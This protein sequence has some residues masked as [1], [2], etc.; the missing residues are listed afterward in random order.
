MAFAQ[1]DGAYRPRTR[2]ALQMFRFN[3]TKINNFYSVVS[4]K[5]HTNDSLYYAATVSKMTS[6]LGSLVFFM[7]NH[8]FYTEGCHTC[9]GAPV[10]Q[11]ELN[12]VRV[13]LNAIMIPSKIVPC[14][15]LEAYMKSFGAFR[16]S[17]G[18]VILNWETISENDNK[19]F[20]VEYSR[21]GKD[22]RPVGKV[23]SLGNTSSG[24][25]YSF[26]HTDPKEGKNYYRLRI[27][28][29][30]GRS[31][32]SEVRNVLFG[33]NLNTLSVYPNPASTT[34]NIQLDARDGEQVDINIFDANGRQVLKNKIVLNNQ[35]G[36]VNVERLHKGIYWI[37]AAT[38][39]GLQYRA[40][41][42][43]SN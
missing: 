3:S 35:I 10:T 19:Y 5:R 18:S 26:T 33:S 8:E 27:V 11:Q 1:F 23:L 24:F 43:I 12:G 40:K 20:M 15:I 38:S 37:M 30:H 7:G 31:K 36:Q 14:I 9:N 4:C 22:F 13:Y 28:D 32:Y 16:Q 21:D 39:K 29:V 6:D 25:R 34:V 17:D 42:L 2:G 41:L